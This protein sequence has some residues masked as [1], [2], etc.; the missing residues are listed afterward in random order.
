MVQPG[1]EHKG[2]IDYLNVTYHL[3]GE[4]IYK[5]SAGIKIIDMAQQMKEVYEVLMNE[6]IKSV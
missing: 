2:K 1:I 5:W 4:I 3:N 6:C